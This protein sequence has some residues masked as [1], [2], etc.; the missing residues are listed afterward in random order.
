MFCETE[1]RGA[2]MTV[3]RPPAPSNHGRMELPSTQLDRWQLFPIWGML[4]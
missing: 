4:P 1:P 2:N 3:P